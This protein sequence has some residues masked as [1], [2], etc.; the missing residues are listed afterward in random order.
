VNSIKSHK[1]SQLVIQ[2]PKPKEAKAP[3]GKVEQ[4][5]KPQKDRKKMAKDQDGGSKGKKKAARRFK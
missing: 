1:A 5:A 3:R 2:P 4:P